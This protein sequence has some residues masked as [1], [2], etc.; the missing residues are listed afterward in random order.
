MESKVEQ[1][2]DV[3]GQFTRL[4]DRVSGRHRVGCLTLEEIEVAVKQIDALYTSPKVPQQVV[5]PEC[6]GLGKITIAGCSGTKMEK[7]PLCGGT[8]H[9]LLGS[10]GTIKVCPKCNGTGKVPQS[11]PALPQEML[12]K[13]AKLLSDSYGDNWT[14]YEKYHD[15][16]AE[17]IIALTASKYEARI[18]ELEKELKK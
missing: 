12:T 7:C 5:C 13:L 14:N 18:K 10:M 17:E 16:I 8:G 6:G 2:K 3:L 1:I 9:W 4:E 15:E 11:E